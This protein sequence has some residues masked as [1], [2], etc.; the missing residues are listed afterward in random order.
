MQLIDED[1]RLLGI[2]N[3]VDALAVAAVLAVVVVGVAAVGVLSGGGEPETRYAT[4]E[5]EEQPSYVIDR[6]EEG[7]E[8]FVEGYDHALTVTDVYATPSSG[9]GAL[10]VRVELAGDLVETGDGDRRFE[11][12]GEPL[13]PGQ[14]LAIETS[15]YGVSG[16]VTSVDPDESALPTAETEVLL[17]TTASSSTVDEI[18]V[19][20]EYQIGPHTVATVTDVETFPVGATDHRVFLG[21][22]LATLEEGAAPT[23]AGETIAT[24]ASVALEMGSYSLEGDVVGQGT[25]SL[26][27]EETTTDATIELFG[28]DPVV[29]ERFEDAATGTGAEP[30]GVS[31]ERAEVE[32]ASVVLG[33][34]DGEIYERENPQRMDVTREVA[35]ETRTTDGSVWFHGESL[36]GGDSIVLA[37]DD[38][39]VEGEV[40]RLSS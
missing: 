21:V 35:L 39:I 36:T 33:S 17:E 8:T 38:R 16:T 31:I 27:G 30:A 22:E 29:A 18:D 9:D 10:T 34:E 37:F 2:A 24:D 1:G 13:Y 28:V 40:T 25:T 5:L 19:D 32:P 20:D 4:I 7:D 23:F 6:L 12:A 11:F 3:A 26:P 14:D 15:D